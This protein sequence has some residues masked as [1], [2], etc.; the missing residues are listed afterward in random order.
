MAVTEYFFLPSCHFFCKRF[1]LI[2]RNKGVFS[3][4]PRRGNFEL[5]H[6][7]SLNKVQFAL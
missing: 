1:S 6:D 5:V 3:F 7:V 2:P 4:A